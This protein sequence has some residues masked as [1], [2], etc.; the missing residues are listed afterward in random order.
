MNDTLA[1]Q[2]TFLQRRTEEETKG[3]CQPT[4]SK[5]KSLFFVSLST[6]LPVIFFQYEIKAR[7]KNS[8]AND[9]RR[10]RENKIWPEVRGHL[11]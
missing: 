3:D 5:K 7:S 10:L 11:K 1:T 9:L 8:G 2:S 6:E 4:E